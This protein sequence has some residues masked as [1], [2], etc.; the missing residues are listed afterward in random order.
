MGVEQGK[1][2]HGRTVKVLWVPGGESSNQPGGL[3]ESFAC[4][5]LPREMFPIYSCT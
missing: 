5:H 3:K 2:F 1:G 4:E